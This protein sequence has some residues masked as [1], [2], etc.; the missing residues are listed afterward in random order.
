[1]HD[2]GNVFVTQPVEL[3]QG[4]G[5]AQV[6]GQLLDGAMDSAFDFIPQQR[7]FWG[8]EILE[9]MIAVVKLR[10]LG[11]HITVWRPSSTGHQVVLRRVDG[12]AVQPGIKRTVTAEIAKRT[13]GLDKGFL[14]YILGLVGVVNEPHDQP[15]NL[16]LIL[17]HQQ[18]ESS[19]VTA[20]NA[21]DKLLILFL[22]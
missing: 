20:L 11:A 19:P 3:A 13:I 17:Q 5:R 16:V 15:E 10:I 21:L 18:I 22:G 8:L 4:Q 1:M 2:T 9:T 7:A 12:D 6:F 14:C